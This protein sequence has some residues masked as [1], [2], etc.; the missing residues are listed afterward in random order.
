MWRS[1]SSKRLAVPYRNQLRHARGYGHGAMALA[2]RGG[3][4]ALRLRLRHHP[5]IAVTRPLSS[6]VPVI[7]GRRLWS[8][9]I[10][11]PINRV[12]AHV[13][14]A[15]DEIAAL[16]PDVPLWGEAVAS[17]ASIAKAP[18]KRLIRPQLVLLGHAAGADGGDSHPDDG[19]ELF[20]AGIELQ[21]LFMLVSLFALAP[22]MS[23]AHLRR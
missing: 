9:N 21:H 13:E 4:V 16:R 22:V 1:S 6:A 18:S 3:G 20:A 14:K 17:L 5:S 23:R 7:D 10:R 19:V 12:S 15:F 11:E 2:R 8:A